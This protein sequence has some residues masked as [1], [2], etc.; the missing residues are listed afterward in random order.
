MTEGRSEGWKEAGRKQGW[1]A[2]L[3]GGGR[4]EGKNRLR[5]GGRGRKEGGREGKETLDSLS[6]PLPL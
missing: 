4:E 5:E 2:D 3:R 6:P 1:Q